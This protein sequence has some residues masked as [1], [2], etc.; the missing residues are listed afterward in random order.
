L[1]VHGGK[2]TVNASWFSYLDRGMPM[3][4]EVPGA[5]RA[6]GSVGFLLIPGFALMSYA[7]AVEP[8]RAANQ[9]AGRKLYRWWHAT[10][11]DAAAGASNGATIIPDFSL[12]SDARS[13]DMMFVCAG[14]NP[15]AFTDRRTFAWL[16]KLASHGVI[17]G[18]ISG[19]AFILARAGLLS[20]RRCTVHWEHA[21]AFQEAFPDIELTQSLFEWDRDR[22]YVL[23]RS[24]RTRHDGCTHHSRS[25]L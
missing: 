3:L 19:G 4:K 12:G 24:G 6:I 13:V 11:A 5:V 2:Y 18:G 9:L 1:T 20:G 25:R 10:P 22:D 16:R 17:I 8:L 21:P 7:A 14:G 15:A 23:R